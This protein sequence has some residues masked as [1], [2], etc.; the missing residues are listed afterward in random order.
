MSEGGFQDAGHLPAN[1]PGGTPPDPNGLPRQRRGVTPQMH[2]RYPE[3][4][5]LRQ[6]GHWDDVTRQVVLGR[7]QPRP[8][9]RFFTGTE[10]AALEAFCDTVTAQDR[11]PRIPV[12]SFVDERLADGRG[13]GYRYADLPDDGEVWRRL[14]AALDEAARGRSD[15]GFAGLDDEHR[16]TICAALAG[17]ALHVP[18]LRGLDQSRV[19]S[20]VMRDVVGA[21]YAHPWAWNEI[22]YGGPA[23]PRGFARLG[24]G[25]SEEWEAAEAFAVDPVSDTQERHLE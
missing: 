10:A 11:E 5:V 22:G 23:Y 7:V 9:Y 4:D 16:H 14:A 17:G 3:H 2:G 15:D 13:E 1:R 8:P 21:F 19:W 18:S 20:I 6:A 12:L 25:Q 24:I